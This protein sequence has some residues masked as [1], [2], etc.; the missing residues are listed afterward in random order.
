MTLYNLFG[1]NTREKYY[2]ADD[3]ILRY[4]VKE[5]YDFM[6]TE[7]III[8]GLVQ[9]VGY[10]P[11]VAECAQFY[12]IKGWVRN[13]Q[14]IVTIMATGNA[15]DLQRFKARL[16]A[17]VPGSRV[18]RIEAFGQELTEFE[19]FIIEESNSCSQKEIPYIPPDLPTCG[20]CEAE[21][22][23]INNRRYRYPFISCTACGARYSIIEELP[24]DRANTLMRDFKLC[25]Q[26]V[27]DYSRGIRRYAQT[28]G[29]NDCG[30]R[31][32]WH[33]AGILQ[34]GRGEFGGKADTDCMETVIKHIS[35]GK[36]AAIKDIGGYHLV[37]L[38]DNAGAVSA[39]RS[40]KTRERK[41][42]AV[43]FPD[44]DTVREYCCVD[45]REEEELLSAAR[46][47]VLLKHRKDGRSFDSGVCMDS[48]EIGCML[49]SNPVQIML[50]D[51]LGPII[52]TSANISGG[53]MITDNVQLE[54]W[55]RDR[56]AGM[57]KVQEYG[58]LSHD[59]AIAA[60][61]DDS[62]VR[63]VAGRRQMIRRAR[64][65]VPEPVKINVQAGI[66][67]AGGDL[68]S[69]FCH[70]AGGR[71]YLSQHFGDLEEESCLNEYNKERIRMCKLF[72]FKPLVKAI[73]A[74]PGYL[75]G[76]NID[77][78]DMRIQHHKAHVASVIAEHNLQGNII[79]I[80]FDGTGYGDDGNIW[81]SEFFLYNSKQK[82]KDFLRAAHLKYVELLGGNECSRNA[83]GV[84]YGYINSFDEA[85]RQKLIQ[86]ENIE[87]DKYNITAKAI[88]HNINRIVS[89]SMGRLFDAVSAFLGICS[90]S[91]YEGEAAIRLEYAAGDE[92]YPLHI[93]TVC[94]DVFVGDTQ[95][96]F[97]EIYDAVNRGVSVPALARGFIIAVA[98]WIIEVCERIIC[99][100]RLPDAAVVLSGG[101][102]FNRIL[103]EELSVKFAEKGLKWYIN[104]QVPSGDGG[105]C[106]GQAFIASEKGLI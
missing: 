47:I 56:S 64:G 86:S 82:D 37:C 81:G 41:P 59:R 36:I 78:A 58:I 14:G 50:A 49:P 17:G 29:C 31:L 87:A 92:A 80:A 84:L 65:F 60:P 97:V 19:S 104:E 12:N 3:I 28:I 2:N 106:L 40:L 73:D 69:V 30:P 44:V 21:L 25:S 99:E 46:P 77:N 48:T 32:E 76:R 54:E 7:F 90:Y 96:L 61:L 91:T 34:N 43:M 8:N 18:F 75:S 4:T 35:S 13:T 57:D 52:M 24:Y 15:D 22:R 93:K 85:A 71:A 26:C 70:T 38:P 23:D 20:S 105:L 74:H 53:L 62:V 55:L 89:S 79:G 51:A 103:V 42:L 5:V 88:K 11:F 67:A 102:F 27:Q 9:G 101:T 95:E 10:R 66:F 68:K 33:I 63:I 45:Y 1:E 72:G 6:I 98:D 83:E 94:E 16:K 100:Y 39:L